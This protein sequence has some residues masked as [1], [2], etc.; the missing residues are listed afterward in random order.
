[1]VDEWVRHRVSTRETGVQVLLFLD[2]VDLFMI[3]F[4]IFSVV[5][6]G[7]VYAT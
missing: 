2:F 3:I 5:R 6:F 4:V 1:M 7:Q